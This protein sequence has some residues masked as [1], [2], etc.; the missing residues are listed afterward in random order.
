MI[1][2]G[3]SA[4]LYEKNKKIGGLKYTCNLPPFEIQGVR[5]TFMVDFKMM[6]AI[7]SGSVIVPGTWI[8]GAR[9]KKWCEMQ[10]GFY[11][12]YAKQI[13]GFYLELPPY[14]KNYT[15]FNCGHMGTHY[16]AKKHSPEQIHM[17]GFDS[18]FGPELFSSTD[19]Y[20]MSDRSEQNNYRLK[21]NWR[22]IWSNL[23]K[24]FPKTEFVLHHFHNSIQIPEVPENVTIQVTK[25]LK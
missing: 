25:T 3:K 8:L 4:G 14:V 9:P 23:F 19:L 12:K 7:A 17:Y 24:E 6:K 20:L 5:A 11:M 10:P 16:I 18:M 21:N 22:P 1:G 15:D 13:A 2:N